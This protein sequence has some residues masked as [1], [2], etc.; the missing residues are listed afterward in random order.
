MLENIFAPV[1]DWGLLVLRIGLAII[2]L[3]HGWL[4]INPNGPVK[5]PAN[6][7]AALKQMGIPLSGLLA[8]IV[9]LQE[10]VGAALLIL[11]LG[12]RI[13]AVL[14]S[15][16]MLVIILHVKGHV[17]KTGFMAQQTTGWELDFAV[18]VGALALL[19]TG[20][21]NIALDPVIGL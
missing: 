20:A 12:T 8:W 14:Y 19:F 17:M 11:G 18:L 6:F 15:I 16:Q 7:G 3:V 13:L 10:T 1:S 4:K 21:G 5:G 2:L 9:V